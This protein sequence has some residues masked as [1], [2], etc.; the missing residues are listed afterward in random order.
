MNFL[1]TDD[2]RVS[3]RDSFFNEITD[4]DTD[5]IDNAEASAISKMKS[6]LRQRYDV[7]QVFNGRNYEDAP[8]IVEYCTAIFLHR[9]AARINPRKIPDNIKDAY[10]EALDWLEK[11]TNLEA[12]PSLP[13][14]AEGEPDSG[15]VL[16][17]SPNDALDHNY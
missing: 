14:I 9:L 15:D 3:L 7:D 16:Y 4:E 1:T 8:L 11:V 12:N 17:Y 5:V 13:E 2:I 6:M 10:M